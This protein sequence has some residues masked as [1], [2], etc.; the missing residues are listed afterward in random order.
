LDTVINSSA[1]HAHLKTLAR[2]R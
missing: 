1:T 2:Y